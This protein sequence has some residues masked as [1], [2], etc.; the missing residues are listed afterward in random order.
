[1]WSRIFTILLAKAG[2]QVTG[3]DLTPDMIKNAKQLAKEEQAECE[4]AVMDARTGVP[5][6]Y[7]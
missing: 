4:F 7:A 1:M 3:I 2:H 5:G 6:R